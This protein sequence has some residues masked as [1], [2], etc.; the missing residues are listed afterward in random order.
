[1]TRI[2]VVRPCSRDRFG[3]IAG[4]PP[5]DDTHPV[6]RTLR[7]QG[8]SGADGAGRELRRAVVGPPRAIPGLRRPR[9]QPRA[10]ATTPTT[11]VRAAASR[12]PD[13]PSDRRW[14]PISV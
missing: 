5:E 3:G 13:R 14:V 7:L 11:I 10:R 2:D 9:D 6:V 4:D 8:E 12:L 1:M